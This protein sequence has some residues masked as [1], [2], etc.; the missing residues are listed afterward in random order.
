MGVDRI[1][2]VATSSGCRAL[3][4]VRFRTVSVHKII[5]I[6]SNDL[7]CIIFLSRW[8]R[9]KLQSRGKQDGL[10]AGQS[11]T[12]TMRGNVALLGLRVHAR[13]TVLRAGVPGA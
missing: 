7:I 10:P 13:A 1:H 2:K 3:E 6:Q 8:P 4:S 9:R 5:A 12:A 11:G